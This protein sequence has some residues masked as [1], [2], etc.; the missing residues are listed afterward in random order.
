MIVEH[1]DTLLLHHDSEITIQKLFFF[2][3]G[4]PNSISFNLVIK[5]YFLYQL[6]LV[7]NNMSNLH[8]KIF[9]YCKKKIKQQQ[10]KLIFVKNKC[11]LFVN[12][13]CQNIV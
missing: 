3:F 12:K 6:V 10:S 5:I 8:R 11:R 2:Y 4:Y 1:H 7:F 13:A 9:N